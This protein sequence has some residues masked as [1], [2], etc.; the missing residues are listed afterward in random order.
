MFAALGRVTSRRPWLVIAAWVVIAVAVAMLAPPLETTQEESEFLPE[1]YESVQAAEIQAE[2][3]PG[4]SAPAA[5]LVFERED[6]QPLTEDD[7]AEV[8]R[9]AE[10]LGP[11]LG[12]DTFVQQV[13]TVGPDGQPNVSQDGQV[14]IG[15]VGLAEGSTG[16]DAQA[17]EDA[18]AM[19]DV[20]ASLT[21]GTD[22]RAMSASRNVL[23]QDRI[24]FGEDGLGR[25]QVAAPHR[26]HAPFEEQLTTGKR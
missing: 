5:L 10:R 1:H 11:E 8:T 19:R 14:Q 4:A 23:G 2:K 22:L 12:K 3:F 9:V 17:F 13:V 21:E 18:E 20:V 7:Q 6:G 16:F 24:E 25:V 15:I 26:A